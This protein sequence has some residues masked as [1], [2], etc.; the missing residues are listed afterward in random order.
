MSGDALAGKDWRSRRAERSRVAAA[1][2]LS[3]ALH[4]LVLF[5]PQVGQQRPD[6]R[7]AIKG[8]QRNTPMLTA[9]LAL[10]G[11]HGFSAAALPAEGEKVPQSST[12]GDRSSE[13]PAPA[14]QPGPSGKGSL[15]IPGQTYYLAD[16]L[17]KRPQPLGRA[18]LDT[19]ETSVIVATGRIVLKLWID[20]GGKVTR[21]D[22][23]SSTMPPLITRAAVA[24][25]E[26]LRFAPGERD[27]RAVG[28]ILRI[29]I[30]Y[31]DGRMLHAR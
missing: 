27:G 23:E 31:D 21:V 17:T 4:A 12:A 29:E 2:G 16:Q 5:V 6:F 9:T 20:D 13:I 26:N 8:E 1:L 18:E 28:T 10:A 11:R 3:C 15:P 14:Q 19:Q 25:F 7:L 22:L 30:E 24:G